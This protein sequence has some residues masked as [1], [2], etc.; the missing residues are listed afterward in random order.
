[1]MKSELTKEFDIDIKTE[2]EKAFIEDQFIPDCSQGSCEILTEAL[3]EELE[4]VNSDTWREDYDPI[5]DHFITEPPSLEEEISDF[6]KKIKARKDFSEFILE[7]ILKLAHG[8]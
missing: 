2:F 4:E 1:M 7:E 8:S 3:S 6:I 5:L